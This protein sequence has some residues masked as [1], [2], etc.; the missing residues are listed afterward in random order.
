MSTKNDFL[1]K[2]QDTIDVQQAKLEQLKDAALDETQETI[3]DIREA[4]N[5]LEPKLEQAK[6]KAMEI[7]DAADD[8]W[9][10]IKDSVEA[11]WDE[12]GDEIE[13]GWDNL[14]D[15]VKNMFS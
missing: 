14:T 4:I 10:D 2:V 7:A 3:E 5:N 8:K 13:K 12:V 11:G 9:D 15:S 6:A 1:A